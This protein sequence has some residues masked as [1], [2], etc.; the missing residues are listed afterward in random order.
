MFELDLESEWITLKKSRGQG[1]KCEEIHIPIVVPNKDHYSD[2]D[3]E[4]ISSIKLKKKE[5]DFVFLL[6]QKLDSSESLSPSDLGE[7][8]VIGID[9]GERNLASSVAIRPS[10]QQTEIVDVEFFDGSK[11]KELEHKESCIRENLQEEGKSGEIPKRSWKSSNKKKDMSE[12]I[13]H[14]IKETAEKINAKAVFIGDLKAPR[15]KNFGSL[16]RRLNNYPFAK[17]KGAIK[18]HLEKV[19]IFVKLVYEGRTED[20]LGTSQKCHKCGSKGERYKGGFSCPSCGLE[21]YNADLNGSVNIAERGM[22][23]LGISEGLG[24]VP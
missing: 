9:L 3:E 4:K 13:A 7:H 16:S 14:E 18:R 17:L 11:A 15:P 6:S 20:D 21:D 2:L 12:K 1:K 19:G 22:K 5:S 10:S 8:P 23:S 24:A